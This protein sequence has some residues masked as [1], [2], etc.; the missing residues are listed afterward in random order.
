M[1]R[2]CV[3]WGRRSSTQRDGG[4]DLG[5]GDVL[6]RDELVRGED[7]VDQLA[8]ASVDAGVGG[9]LAWEEAVGIP[10]AVAVADV[11]GAEPGAGTEVDLGAAGAVDDLGDGSE[12]LVVEVSTTDHR[13][14]RPGAGAATWWVALGGE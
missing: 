2:K 9:S 11:A 1:V 4:D 10:H 14:G 12:W 8:S 7:V 5:G 6:G 13:V 3:R